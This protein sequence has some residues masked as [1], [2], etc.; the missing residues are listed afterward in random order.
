LALK[1]YAADHNGLYPDHHLG[2]V[3]NSNRVFDE[4]IS[5]GIVTSEKIFGSPNSDFI[6]DEDLSTP[7]ASLSNQVHWA[8]TT[9]LDD[10]FDGGAAVTFE[11]P[12]ARSGVGSPTWG[13]AGKEIRGRVWS[14]P[15][16]IIGTNDG[17]V[18]TFAVDAVHYQ[19]D[20]SKNPDPLV[21]IDPVTYQ[22]QELPWVAGD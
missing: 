2:A 17:A 14:G 21:R 20:Q 1:L 10:S 6:P 11:N 4:L 5:E 18:Q 19:I 9:G 15:R 16:I 12:V 22:K 7:L 8:Y 13:P 3:R